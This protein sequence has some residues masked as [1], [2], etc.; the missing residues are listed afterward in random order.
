MGSPGEM[1]KDETQF[2]PLRTSSVAVS[3]QSRD[4]DVRPEF[5][6]QFLHLSG[7]GQAQMHLKMG[8]I[9]IAIPWGCYKDY[10]M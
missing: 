1:R 10:R 3:M 2:L 9:V 4:P 7:F 6:S 8:I 5:G